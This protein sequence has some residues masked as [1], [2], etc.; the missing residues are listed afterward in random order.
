[1]ANFLFLWKTDLEKFF[2]YKFAS[3]ESADREN[4]LFQTVNCRFIV[5]IECG[6]KLQNHHP[7][8]KINSGFAL[9]L[10]STLDL[11]CETR[12]TC[13]PFKLSLPT[14]SSLGNANH[15]LWLLKL[16]YGYSFRSV[17]MR[18]TRP[19]NSVVAIPKILGSVNWEAQCPE[20]AALFG[21]GYIPQ[22]SSMSKLFFSITVSLTV[23]LTVSGPLV[24]TLSSVYYLAH[25]PKTPTIKLLRIK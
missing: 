12:E 17:E 6:N 9:P 3:Y 16:Y 1:M 8:A 5:L 4:R 21:I 2:G 11:H 22:Y 14:I 25:V 7:W 15:P 19:I 18:Y 23:M 24:P 20:W 10:F 13:S